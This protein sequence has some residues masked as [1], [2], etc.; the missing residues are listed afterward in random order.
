MFCG[1][2]SKKNWEKSEYPRQDKDFQE[3]NSNSD[4]QKKNIYH[5]T[6]AAGMW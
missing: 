2:Y 6:L 3:E 1:T 5:M 4:L